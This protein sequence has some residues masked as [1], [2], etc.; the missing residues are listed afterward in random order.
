MGLVDYRRGELSLALGPI[1]GL[2]HLG[3]VVAVIHDGS[4]IPV[5]SAEFLGQRVHGHDDVAGAVELNLVVIDERNQARRLEFCGGH[6]GLPSLAFV[7]VAVTDK[8]VGPV[9]LPQQPRRQRHS[10]CYR[11]AV[12]QRPGGHLHA[13]CFAHAG[14]AL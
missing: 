5:E 4:D 9:A 10:Q 11:G 1:Q 14:V 8:N 3:G 13:R 7:E 2:Q 12:S 6:D